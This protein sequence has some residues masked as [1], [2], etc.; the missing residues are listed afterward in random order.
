MSL[1]LVMPEAIEDSPEFRIREMKTELSKL[2]VVFLVV[3]FAFQ[4]RLRRGRRFINLDKK[5]PSGF[6]LFIFKAYGC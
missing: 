2:F 1:S 4:V 6:F 3:I 5:N